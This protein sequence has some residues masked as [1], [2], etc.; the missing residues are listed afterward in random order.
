MLNILIN[1]DYQYA[2]FTTAF[3]YEK[4]LKKRE[5]VKVF[6]VGE[7]KDTETDIVINFMPCSFYLHPPGVFK[8]Y[9]EG[10]SHMVQGRNTEI[11]GVMDLIFQ[12]QPL[13]Q[14]LY[15]EKKTFLLYH[16]A[17]PE[18]H[19]PFPKEEKKFDVSFLGNDTY[20]DRRIL[21]DIIGENFS[22]LRSNSKP[23]LPYSKKLS[24]G[25]CIFNK[26]YLN[27]INMR[28]FEAMAI[29]VPLITDDV[30]FLDYVGIEGKH[31]LTYNS[32]F[33]LLNQIKRI[34]KDGELREEISRNGRERVLKFHTYD[35]RVAQ[36]LDI[37]ESKRLKK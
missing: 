9:W 22:L 23:G 7:I 17:D 29:G 18:L 12:C 25:K 27:D 19:K 8:V 11:Y 24:S 13:Y 2:P 35:H 10:D 4:A 32:T 36:M 37:I 34:L 14:E 31:F 20:P 30:K 16:A 1:Y 6:R 26:S 15:P 33:S 28:I 5:D 21:L 3:Y